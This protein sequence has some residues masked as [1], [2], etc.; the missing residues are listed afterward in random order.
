MTMIEIKLNGETVQ[1]HRDTRGIIRHADKIG[2]RFVAVQR[3]V[4]FGA[5]VNVS[6]ADDSCCETTFADFTVALNWF[7]ERAER[8]GLVERTN[9]PTHHSWHVNT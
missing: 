1:R 7:R 4:S 2:V 5:V 9:T 8:W 6:F 3:H